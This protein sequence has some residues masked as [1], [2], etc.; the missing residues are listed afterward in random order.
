MVLSPCEKGCCH[1][2]LESCSQH[3]ALFLGRQQW[4]WWLDSPRCTLYP[5]TVTFK[6]LKGDLHPLHPATHHGDPGHTHTHRGK[7]HET[8][9][10][11][12]MCS[13]LCSVLLYCLF[14]NISLKWYFLTHQLD[15]MTHNLQLGKH[16]SVPQFPE[17][18][19]AAH[20]CQDASYSCVH[21]AVPFAQNS[22]PIPATNLW[23]ANSRHLP[24]A[25]GSN[26]AAFPPVPLSS[27]GSASYQRMPGSLFSC[28]RLSHPL[29]CALT[30][31]RTLSYWSLSPVPLV[32]VCGSQ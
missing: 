32:L 23:N 12:T 9:L 31:P 14:Y 22:C 17:S 2:H 25:P 6:L 10:I 18:L 20:G 27:F 16:Y 7:F 13:E 4:G 15:F 29:A 5:Q 21:P 11:L 8:V 19:A 1:L 30:E 3:C 28:A 26:P 24:D